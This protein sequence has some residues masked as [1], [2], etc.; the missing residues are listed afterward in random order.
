MFGGQDEKELHHLINFKVRL[1]TA[2][3]LNEQAHKFLEIV[4]K[5]AIISTPALRY[6]FVHKICSSVK[7]REMIK[8]RRRA[9]YR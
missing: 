2:K 7:I 6:S 5:A 9:R 4:S 1:E 3:D 8:E